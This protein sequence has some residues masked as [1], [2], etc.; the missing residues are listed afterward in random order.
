MRSMTLPEDT[1]RTAS[2]GLLLLAYGTQDLVQRLP[3]TVRLK[4]AASLLI[5]NRHCLPVAE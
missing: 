3:L 2:P 4:R 5:R 1:P